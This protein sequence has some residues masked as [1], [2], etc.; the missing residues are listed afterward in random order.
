MK[1]HMN[2]NENTPYQD[3][4]LPMKQHKHVLLIVVPRFQDQ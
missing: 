3:F 2:Y 1:P 4:D